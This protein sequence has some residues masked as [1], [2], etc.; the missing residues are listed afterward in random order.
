MCVA[1][2]TVSMYHCFIKTLLIGGSV[3]KKWA[4][5]ARGVVINKRDIISE[6]TS[7]SAQFKNCG[8]KVQ[9]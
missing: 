8:D 6:H 4:L 3:R 5:K 9:N 2:N 1:T 7:F